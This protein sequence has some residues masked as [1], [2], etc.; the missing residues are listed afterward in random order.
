LDLLLGLD[1][2]K[3]LEILALLGF[4]TPSA[5]FSLRFDPGVG[6]G[7]LP[8]LRAVVTGRAPLVTPVFYP[9]FPPLTHFAVFRREEAPGSLPS[10]SATK[11]SQRRFGVRRWLVLSFW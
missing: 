4:L 1:P 6:T 5:S 7:K 8:A 9:A 3:Y 2:E 11:G 10:H